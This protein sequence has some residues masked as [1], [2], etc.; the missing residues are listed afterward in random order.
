MNRSASS[1]SSPVRVRR[2]VAG[3]RI[4]PTASRASP[5]PDAAPTGGAIWDVLALQWDL[6]VLLRSSVGLL[7]VHVVAAIFALQRV[8][9]E[10]LRG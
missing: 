6:L 9:G 4:P 5:G 2:G 8:Q 3:V 10:W 1:P 7:F